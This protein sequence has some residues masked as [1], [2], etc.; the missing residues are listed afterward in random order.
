MAFTN[1]ELLLFLDSGNNIY[2]HTVTQGI[3]HHSISQGNK[4]TAGSGDKDGLQVRKVR[5]RA[6]DVM[7][8]LLAFLSSHNAAFFNNIP[9]SRL[10]QTGY[11]S[12][13][14]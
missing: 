13:A 6:T 9:K 4:F 10:V 12:T 11:L 8:E 14:T 3:N 1:S 2:L 5:A 7:F